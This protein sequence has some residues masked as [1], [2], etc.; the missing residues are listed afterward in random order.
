MVCRECEKNIGVNN[1][2]KVFD[3]GSWKDK[4]VIN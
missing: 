1:E 2:F 4:V 3:L